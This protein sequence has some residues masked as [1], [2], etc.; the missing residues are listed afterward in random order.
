MPFPEIGSSII[1]L[2]VGVISFL[3]S[4]AILR[5]GKGRKD[6]PPTV[7]ETPSVDGVADAARYVVVEEAGREADA[8]ADAVEDEHPATAVAHLVNS[9]RGAR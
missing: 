2:A 4:F 1:A 7:P 5:S 9:R 8:V 3:V 6:N